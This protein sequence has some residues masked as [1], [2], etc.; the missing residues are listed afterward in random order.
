LN[1]DG[2]AMDEVHSTRM[3]A[4]DTLRGFL[5]DI[6]AAAGCARE[7]ADRIARYLVA[8]N[9][10]GHDSHGAVRTP[11]YV[12]WLHEGRVKAGQTITI[13]CES[14]ILATVDGHFGFGQTVVPQAVDLGIAKAKASGLSVIALRR[15]GHAGRIG[16]WAE[17]AAAAGLVSIHFANVP[18]GLMVAPFA[19]VD[20]RL[21][22]N[23]FTIAVPMEEGRP[24]LL[25]DFATSLVAEGKVQIASRGGKKVP[26]GSLIRPDGQLT[27]DP[28]AL[29][30][31][32]IP[33]GPRDGSKGDGALVP[34][35]L[36]KGSG[37]AFM[38]EILAG[39][40]SGGAT[41][42]PVP[43]GSMLLSNCLLSIYLDPAHFGAADFVR[44]VREFVDYVKSSRPAT[45]GGEVLVPGE[46]EARTR[47]ERLAGGIPLQADTWAAIVGT[48]RRLGVEPPE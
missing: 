47:A 38:C 35:G 34:F 21:S 1:L 36:H 37:I 24:P 10:A 18:G 2:T 27:S 7:E 16:D 26:E 48:G 44:R 40:L 33:G 4:A 19:G 6:F 17:R 31:P 46:P 43:P 13:V 45:P 8:A 22:T 30:G 42:G 32:L 14:P 9:L 28:V 20:R 23:P 39:L 5:A 15:T 25:L 29:Y 3:V 41:S 12:Q 11:A